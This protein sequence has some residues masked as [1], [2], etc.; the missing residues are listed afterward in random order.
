MWEE[1]SSLL[2]ASQK[3]KEMIVSK[4][5]N[6]WEVETLRNTQKNSFTRRRRNIGFLFSYYNSQTNTFL[7]RSSFLKKENRRLVREHPFAR[8]KG[9][10]FTSVYLSKNTKYGYRQ[11]R[12]AFSTQYREVEERK[13][14][15]STPGTINNYFHNKKNGDVNAFLNGKKGKKY[16]AEFV[17]ATWFIKG[18]MESKRN[19]FI[20]LQCFNGD[21]SAV[22]SALVNAL[23]YSEKNGYINMGY[24]KELINYELK[25]RKFRIAYIKP[26]KQILGLNAVYLAFFGALKSLGLI[27]GVDINQLIN[28]EYSEKLL[29]KRKL[30]LNA[31]MNSAIHQKNLLLKECSKIIWIIN[32]ER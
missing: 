29:D 21:L 2:D 32:Q 31:G 13:M 26:K 12:H 9:Y 8:I 27:P 5:I 28:E 25:R 20:I 23:C 4:E 17:S 15:I 14:I 10:T 7:I 30:L 18:L 1:Y 22:V 3:A 24:I 16:I 11:R 19:A 6:G